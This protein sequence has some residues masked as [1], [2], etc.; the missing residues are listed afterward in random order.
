MKQQSLFTIK[1]FKQIKNEKTGL[2]IVKK[3]RKKKEE[4]LQLQVSKYLRSQYPGVIFNSDI[5]SGLFLPIWIAAKAKAQRSE[6]GLPDLIIL[7]PHGQY[8]AL[9]LELKKEGAKIFKQ[10]GTLYSDKHLEEQNNLLARLRG[11]GYYANFSV[12]WIDTKKQID[13]YFSL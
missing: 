5:A 8:H 11:K 4:S 13:D 1:E 2:P 10:D 6:R 3:K 9:C 7:E 12:G